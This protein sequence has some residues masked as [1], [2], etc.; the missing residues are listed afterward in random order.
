MKPGIKTM[1][2]DFDR[3]G[4][5][6][7]FRP[8]IPKQESIVARHPQSKRLHRDGRLTMA[9][10]PLPWRAYAAHQSNLNARASV[11]ATYDE[12]AIATQ[13]CAKGVRF[14]MAAP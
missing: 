14:A 11:D 12:S 9:D 1:P 13:L 6:T 5:D 10:I 3:L 4:P 8:R 2:N 7:A